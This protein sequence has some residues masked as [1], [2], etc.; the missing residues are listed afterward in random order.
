MLVE[1]GHDAVWVPEVYEQDP[2]DQ[3]VIRHAFESKRVLL[4][5]DKDFGELIFLHGSQHTGVIRL[6]PMRPDT[7]LSVVRTV[8]NQYT[9]HL[10]R[11]A[12]LT[13]STTRVR[14]RE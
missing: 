13:V 3:A 4:T 10:L 6:E 2:G 8:L 9:A 7:Q 5:A 14:I 1:E 12:I 11:G